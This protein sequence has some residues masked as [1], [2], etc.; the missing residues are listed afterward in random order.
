MGDKGKPA[1]WPQV[2]FPLV[3]NLSPAPPLSSVRTSEGLGRGGRGLGLVLHSGLERRPFRLVGSGENERVVG[4]GISVA[5][6]PFFI[7][8]SAK[9]SGGGGNEQSPVSQSSAPQL[10][11][12]ARRARLGD[13]PD[14]VR[15]V[16]APSLPPYPHHLRL[17]WIPGCQPLA[18]G[19]HVPPPS[20]SPRSP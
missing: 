8:L 17:F 15:G 13:T 14:P 20:P 10:E 12:A 2:R 11:G 3:R 9:H 7:L 16:G 19:F 5:Q 6:V 1:D 18:P 4:G